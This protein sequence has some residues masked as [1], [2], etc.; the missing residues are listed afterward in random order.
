MKTLQQMSDEEVLELQNIYG[1][2]KDAAEAL[3]LGAGALRSRASRVRKKREAQGTVPQNEL[4]AFR[5]SSERGSTEIPPRIDAPI[6]RGGQDDV[7]I[8]DMWR[9]AEQSCEKKIHQEMKREK[10]VARFA[11]PVVAVSFISDQ[12]IAPGTPCDLKRMR[13]D[14]ELIRRTPGLYAVLGG[15]GTDNHI[16]HRSAILGAKSTPTEQWMLY[17][18][19]LNL[20]GPKLVCAVTGNHDSWTVQMAGIDMLGWL[21]RTNK[22]VT[23]SHGAQLELNVGTQQYKVHCRHQYRYNS[24]FNQ[25]HAVKQ[26]LRMGDYD[27]DIGVIGHHHEAAMEAFMWRGQQRWACRP[28]AYQITSHHSSQYGY[29]PAVPTCPT[30][31][32][33]GQERDIVGFFDVRTAVRYL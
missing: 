9:E 11:E 1:S 30:F 8:E 6:V 25:T 5:E 4:Q 2:W 32:L 28:G 27:F 33:S 3:G 15:D 14:A 19:Y 17:E 22:L 23:A 18:Y 20:L 21:G 26:L 13:E 10:F 12:H 24:G 16:K 7:Q 29:S 31:L